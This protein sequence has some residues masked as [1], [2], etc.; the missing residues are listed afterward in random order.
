V[1]PGPSSNSYSGRI[2]S[3][4]FYPLPTQSDEE[5]DNW[6][7]LTPSILLQRLGAHIQGHGLIANQGGGGLYLLWRFS[8]YM[9]I[10]V[11]PGRETRATLFFDLNH[12]PH[13]DHY[14]A[15][16]FLYHSDI[17]EANS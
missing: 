3:T 9:Q 13:E 11:F 8:D 10:R 5:P 17:C 1:L 15:F 12:P 2:R 4:A 16:Q 6:G 14:S 7:T